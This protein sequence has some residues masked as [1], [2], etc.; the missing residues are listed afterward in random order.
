MRFACHTVAGVIAV[1]AL[2][3]AWLGCEPDVVELR[4][5]VLEVDATP[6]DALADTAAVVCG[7][8]LPCD[9]PD[10]CRDS[11]CTADGVCEAPAPRRCSAADP[12]SGG[13]ECRDLG[14]PGELCPG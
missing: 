2:V 1:A 13:E 12:C 6:A 7:C 5:A 10:I 4:P 11:P 3:V 8:L 14:A 9:G